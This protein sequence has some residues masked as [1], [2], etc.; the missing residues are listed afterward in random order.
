MIYVKLDI[1]NH[2]RW[3]VRYVRSCS[4]CVS[5]CCYR[6]GYGTLLAPV[7][8]HTGGAEVV[9]E[10]GGVMW[11][12]DYYYRESFAYIIIIRFY[13]LRTFLTACTTLFAC[14]VAATSQD[15]A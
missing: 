13:L 4:A 7:E 12:F 5:S 6:E 15:L 1:K 11:F 8:V 3:F 9:L 2:I 10:F 14:G